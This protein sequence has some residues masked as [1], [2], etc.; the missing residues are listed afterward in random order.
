MQ[1]FLVRTLSNIPYP[2][3]CQPQKKLFFIFLARHFHPELLIIVPGNESVAIENIF[4][5]RRGDKHPFIVIF[6]ER[7]LPDIQLDRLHPVSALHGHLQPACFDPDVAL[8]FRPAEHPPG[9]R[10]GKTGNHYAENHKQIGA[11]L[12][13]EKTEDT[14][15]GIGIYIIDRQIYRP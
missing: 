6:N 14:A 13:R 12:R 10:I 9:C 5:S 7:N 15:I 3:R 2:S 1:I 8:D 4:T 11:H